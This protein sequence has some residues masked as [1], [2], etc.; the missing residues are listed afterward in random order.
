MDTQIDELV[1]EYKIFYLTYEKMND[2]I[3]HLKILYIYG[4]WV[5]KVILD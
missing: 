2:V 1:S 3:L 5:G 4:E